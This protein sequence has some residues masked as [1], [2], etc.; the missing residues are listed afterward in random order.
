[1]TVK[2]RV[3]AARNQ[4]RA[5][6]A[7]SRHRTSA[8]RWAVWRVAALLLFVVVVVAVS[9][10]AVIADRKNLA[11]LKIQ[12]YIGTGAQRSHFTP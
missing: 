1:M 8:G 7:Q 5:L 2:A 6:V 9:V 12:Q 3:A 10:H 11:T 4:Q